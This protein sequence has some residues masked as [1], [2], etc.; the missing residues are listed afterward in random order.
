MAIIQKNDVF[1]YE[2]RKYRILA[3]EP[4]SIVWFELT[5]G[6]AWPTTIDKYVLLGS[7]E[8]GEACRTD[9]PFVAPIILEPT[10]KH[11]SRRDN[12]YKTIKHIVEHPLFYDTQVR[13]ELSNKAKKIYGT[14]DKVINKRLKQY[15]TYGQSKNA[16]YPK[17]VNSGAPGQPRIFTDK[18]S[19]RPRNNLTGSLAISTEDVRR[20]YSRAIEKFYFGKKT[21]FSAAYRKDV[22][23]LVGTATEQA[24]GPGS[25]Y[26]VD[27]TTADI[28]LV[29]D[30]DPD[31]VIGRPTLY[32]LIDVFTRMVAGFYIG[33][34]TPSYQTVLNALVNA[35][36]P[37]DDSL[38]EIGESDIGLWPV[39]GLPEVLL[40]DKGSE[41]FGK[42][43]DNLLDVFTIHVENAPAYRGD[44]KG[45]VERFFRSWQNGFKN[46]VEGVVTPSKLKKAGE[47]DY[48]FDANV[49]ISEFRRLMISGIL[50]H[51]HT[52]ISRSYDRARDI[53]D[54][55]PLTPVNL[56]NWGIQNRSGALKT[57]EKEQL[58]AGLLPKAKATTSALG[59][60]FNGVYYSTILSENGGALRQ[61]FS[62]LGKEYLIAYDP[63]CLNLIYVF[64]NSRRNFLTATIN[65]RS[66]QFVDMT[67]DEIKARQKKQKQVETIVKQASDTALAKVEA[68]GH[69]MAEKLAKQ[70]RQTPGLTRASKVN[71][72]AKNKRQAQ[73]E[74]RLQKSDRLVFDD[75][76]SNVDVMEDELN[77]NFSSPTVT[78][79]IKQ[80]RKDAKP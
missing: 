54:T 65:K 60:C 6:N 20:L 8:A 21:S 7:I 30:D 4:S 78:Y 69:K 26:E 39:S 3:V 22:R 43:S 56:W 74:E 68:N 47:R 23:A 45:I 63:F 11:I 44:A 64:I 58:F 67:L 5:Q 18:R 35:A 38:K 34:Q 72:I 77:Q 14:T 75:D 41:F 79:L 40:A 13:I 48:R 19:G 80:Q 12:A 66:R 49:P 76:N 71:G 24:L 61:G 1:E 55:L 32:I 52:K 51:N 37:K 57:I 15:W 29:S 59:L 33:F 25:R 50:A 73:K 53:P 42:Q 28:Y 62:E 9:D 10:Q 31:R 2:D 27:A 70:T 16:L 46:I 36:L 17:Y